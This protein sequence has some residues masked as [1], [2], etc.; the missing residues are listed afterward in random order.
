MWARAGRGPA[1]AQRAAWFVL[2]RWPSRPVKAAALPESPPTMALKT[3][4]QMR[5]LSRRLS[6][7][8]EPRARGI[9][10][11][12]VKGE[13]CSADV[14]LIVSQLARK[15]E[16]AVHSSTAPEDAFL[17]E[18]LRLVYCDLSAV[19]RTWRSSNIWR[20]WWVSLTTVITKDYWHDNYSWQMSVTIL[21]RITRIKWKDGNIK[22]F[23]YSPICPL[24]KED[25]GKREKESAALFV[26][27]VSFL[28]IFV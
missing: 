9:G 10:G 27:F 25:G 19:S 4:M 17:N 11:A 1:A 5:D 3:I 22:T 23:N 16:K 15:M 7:E 13:S 26:V 12:R 18:R 6:Q 14:R 24:G 2:D 8:G 28:L 20:A 21:L